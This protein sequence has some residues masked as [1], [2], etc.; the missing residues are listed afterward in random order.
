LVLSNIRCR[1]ASPCTVADVEYIDLLLF[2]QNPVDHAIDVWLPA[3][4]QVSEPVFFPRDRTAQ[5]KLLQS[6]NSLFEARVP[7]Q[8]CIGIVGVDLFI[9]TGEVALCAGSQFNGVYHGRS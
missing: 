7:L 3:V 5:G 1:R 4:E 2:L 8:G 6:E 9:Q